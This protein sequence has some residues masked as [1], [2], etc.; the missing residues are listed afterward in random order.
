M[1]IGIGLYC[2]LALA[3]A[4]LASREFGR[5]AVGWFLLSLNHNSFGRSPA[6]YAPATTTALP[7]LR[8]IHSAFGGSVSILRTGGVFRDRGIGSSYKDQSTV[9]HPCGCRAVDGSVPMPVSLWVVVDRE[10][11]A[12]GQDALAFS[13]QTWLLL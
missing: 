3:V 13:G 12:G 9:A 6:L 11:V 5:S 4:L 10:A 2:L 8:R 7:V 1:G